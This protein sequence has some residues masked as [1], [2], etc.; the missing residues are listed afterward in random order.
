[1][2]IIVD[3]PTRLQCSRMLAVSFKKAFM[4]IRMIILIKHLPI[5]FIHHLGLLK[6]AGVVWPEKLCFF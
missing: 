3:L 1:M 4:A 2:R 6:I 5:R